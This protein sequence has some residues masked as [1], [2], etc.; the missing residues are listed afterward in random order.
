MDNIPNGLG[1]ME[2]VDFEEPNLYKLEAVMMYSRE[3]F[4]PKSRSVALTRITISF[5]EDFELTPA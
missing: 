3:A 5:I 2:P 4:A 1:T